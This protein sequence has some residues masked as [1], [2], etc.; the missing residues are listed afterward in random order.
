MNPSLTSQTQGQRENL[1]DWQSSTGEYDSPYRFNGK[2]LDAETGNYYYGARYYNPKISVWLSVDPL[3]HKYPSLSPY[4][5]TGNNPI[6]LVD[7]DGRWVDDY[8]GKNG[9]YLGSDGIG[10]GVRVHNSATTSQEFKTA[11]TKEGIINVRNNSREVQVLNPPLLY[12]DKKVNG[13]SSGEGSYAIILDAEN[14]IVY[15]TKAETRNSSAYSEDVL[16]KEVVKPDGEV[17]HK[18]LPGDKQSQVLIGSIHRH[19]SGEPVS[20]YEKPG[21][22]GENDQASAIKYGISIF[23]ISSKEI[24]GAFPSGEIAYDIPSE[25]LF[26]KSVK[27][28]VESKK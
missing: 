2:E 12:I 5:F 25:T 16:Y 11:L 8:F 1:N 22:D 13:N 14:A 23:A 3:A 19:E 4:V 7:P 18:I 17:S 28:Y 6:M 9:V 10:N 20:T 21:V 27:N 24:S 26:S 15:M